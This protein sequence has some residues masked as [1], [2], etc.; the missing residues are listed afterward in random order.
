MRVNL[1]LTSVPYSSANRFGYANI[2]ITLVGIVGKVWEVKR[3]G[4][5]EM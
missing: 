5:N 1:Y 2:K 3:Y 4:E